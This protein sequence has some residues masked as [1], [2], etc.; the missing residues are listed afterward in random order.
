[1][2]ATSVLLPDVIVH[3]MK[4]WPLAEEARQCFTQPP[5]I[6]IEIL[7]LGDSMAEMEEKCDAYE[8]MGIPNIWLINPMRQKGKVW[9]HGDWTEVTRFVVDG[10]EIYLDLDWL[11]AQMAS[12]QRSKFLA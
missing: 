11:F 12:R 1:M 7:S 4:D 5:M 2:T 9:K 8:A 10:S 3:P 6:V